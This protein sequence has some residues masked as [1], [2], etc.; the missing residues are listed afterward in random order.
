MDDDRATEDNDLSWQ[1]V[2]TPKS[3]K[4]LLTEFPIIFKPKRPN[5]SCANKL[6]NN[7]NEQPSTSKYKYHD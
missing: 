5:S 1:V 6:I 3:Q 7:N 4:L 2:P